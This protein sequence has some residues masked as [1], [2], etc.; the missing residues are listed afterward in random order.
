[1]PFS[2]HSL[3]F[4]FR[5]SF[6]VIS[7]FLSLPHT[8]WDRSLPPVLGFWS[9]PWAGEVQVGSGR[10]D[11]AGEI[12][13]VLGVPLGSPRACSP[14][15][16]APCS[17]GSVFLRVGGKRCEEEKSGSEPGCRAQI[18]QTMCCISKP[19]AAQPKRPPLSRERRAV[20]HVCWARGSSLHPVHPAH[21][22]WTFND[23]DCR[24]L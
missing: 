1:M 18:I 17:L 5:S 16:S 2:E 3:N 19:W 7:V 15:G 6:R 21:T 20:L 22:L 11:R 13:A 24:G 4:T 9:S 12:P 8:P 14:R 23:A 10:K